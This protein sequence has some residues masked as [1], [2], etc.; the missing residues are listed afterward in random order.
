MTQNHNNLPRVSGMHFEPLKARQRL[1]ALIVMCSLVAASNFLVQPQ[2]HINQ[3]LTFGAL[4]YPVTFLVTDLLNRRFGP[5]AARSIVYWG[6]AA[7]LI[8]SMFISTP[9]IAFASALAFLV[10]HV[11][12]VAVFH[13]LRQASWWLAP[14]IAGILAAIVDTFVFFSTSFMGTDVPWITLMLGDLVIK[15]SLSVLML[16]PFR[17]LMWNLGASRVRN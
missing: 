9:R 5:K 6:F 13:R 16:A 17:A 8:V 3:W 1:L 11:L 12:D 10:A 7:A 4:T 15:V 2:Y 14:L